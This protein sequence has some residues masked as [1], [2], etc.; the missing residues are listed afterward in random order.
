[1]VERYDT[2]QDLDFYRK[3]WSEAYG[4][5]GQ[6]GIYLLK[7]REL[8]L[9][10][11]MPAVDKAGLSTAEFDALTTL[12]RSPPPHQ[13]TPTELQRSMLITSGGL[14]KILYQLEGKGLVSRS[15]NEQDKRVKYVN[16]TLKGKTLVEKTIQDV[17]KLQ[18]EWLENA[19][20]KEEIDELIRL[21][22]KSVKFLEDL[23]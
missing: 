3:Y 18:E 5:T 11:V 4:Q 19:L 13:A 20:T 16:L 2:E 14:T 1:M 12:R 7:A 17:H 21:L 23:T 10:K 22:G 8:S 9:Q 6:F 15:A